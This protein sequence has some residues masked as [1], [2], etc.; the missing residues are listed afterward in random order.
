MKQQAAVDFVV[1]YGL[2]LI[3]ILIALTVIF[4]IGTS[5]PGL[6]APSCTAVPG[7]T[8]DFYSINISGVLTM[9]LTQAIGSPLTIRGVSC[10]SQI[11]STGNGPQYGN[12]AVGKNVQYYYAPTYPVGNVIYS[13]TYYIFKVNCY[14]GYG[15]ANSQKGNSFTGY[16]WLNYSIQ[17]YGNETQRIATVTTPYE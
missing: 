5:N 13:D 10:S 3:V 17:S 7:F 9:R 15:Q 12:V 16:I 2:A 6:S 14:N 11:N 4:R 1:S 8:C